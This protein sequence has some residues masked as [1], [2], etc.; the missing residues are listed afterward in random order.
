V[1]AA[2]RYREWD[3]AYVLGA[4]SPDERSEFEQHLAGCERCR[5][6]VGEL[7]GMPGLLA[8]VPPAEAWTMLDDEPEPEP[9]RPGS[10]T[11]PTASAEVLPLPARSPARLPWWQLVAAAVLVAVL[12][13][14]G[15]YGLR[16]LAERDAAQRLAFSAVVPS[17]LTAVVDLAPVSGGTDVRVECQY[18]DTT[19]GDAYSVWV[20]DTRGRG[21]EV[22]PWTVRPNRVMHPSGVSPLPLDSIAAVEIR[23]GDEGAVLLRARR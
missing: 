19:A 18:A 4:L 2:D 9:D 23:E 8:Q 20:V 3:A 10:P 5:S 7:A 11:T 22:K 21:S 16:S 12:G 6:A 17:P 14:L 1:S 13:G 15:G